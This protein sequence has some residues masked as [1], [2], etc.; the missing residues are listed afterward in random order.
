[1]KQMS[2]RINKQPSVLDTSNSRP[3][4][5]RRF[6]IYLDASAVEFEY[7]VV[8][9]GGGDF[10]RLPRMLS[11]SVTSGT[12]RRS[13]IAFFF[14]LRASIRFVGEEMERAVSD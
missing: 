1:M 12:A 14:P 6:E 9:F 2:E 13:L 10:G 7:G 4:V 8:V 5:R 3:S 11:V